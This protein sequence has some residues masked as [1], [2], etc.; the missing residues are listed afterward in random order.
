[1]M[2]PSKVSRSTM[3]AQ[4]RGSVKV[5]VQPE[6][7]FVGGDRDGGLLLPFGE[8][9]EQQFGAAAVEFHVAE[10]V[11]AEQIDAAVAGDGPGQLLVVGGL[12]ELVDQLGGQG[13]ADPVARASAAAVPSA[14]SRWVLPVPESP[15]RHSGWPARTQAQV[16][17]GGSMAGLMAGLAAK[18]KSSSRFGRGN[19]AAWIRRAARRLVAVV[20][21]GH[22]QLGEEPEVGQLF[23]LGG[24]GDLGEPGPDGRQP[25]RCGSR[26]RSPRPRPARSAAAGR[27]GRSRSTAGQLVAV[28][29]R[30]SSWSYGG[31][32]RQRPRVGGQHR[33]RLQVVAVAA[34]VRGSGPARPASGRRRAGRRRC[35]PRPRP[36]RRLADRSRSAAVI[37][38]ITS[39]AGRWRCS[40]STSISARVPAA[41]PSRACGRMPRTPRAPG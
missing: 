1:M 4:S 38:A 9:L 2:W 31:D 29:S 24:G 16:A 21:L 17:S 28:A 22:H 26:P 39:A 37:P 13:V 23:A 8:D 7:G 32:R 33:H 36:R 25:Q 10:F 11:E 12:D 34:F 40:S 30:V 14:I 5:L 20:A 41:S 27:R 35:G 15:I 3:A 18:S 19:P 6:N